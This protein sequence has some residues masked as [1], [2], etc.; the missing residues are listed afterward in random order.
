M[1][2]ANALLDLNTT[3]TE[4]NLNK[5]NNNDNLKP[6]NVILQEFANDSNNSLK[7][8][9]KP[10]PLPL[11]IQEAININNIHEINEEI[12]QNDD[13]SI[14]FSIS[15]YNTP[16]SSPM[17]SKKKEKNKTSSKTLK[18]TKS[19]K[20]RSYIDHTP[21]WRNSENT[22][23]SASSERKHG[24][25]KINVPHQFEDYQMISQP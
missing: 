20:I 3:S 16:K 17:S 1:G 6:K 22:T 5:I 25:R 4:T 10:L 12:D 19:S 23:L 13:Y 14:L 9:F 24:K 8:A 2:I 21:K 18:S 15:N 11:E 7:N